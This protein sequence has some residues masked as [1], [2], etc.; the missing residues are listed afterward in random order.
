M[1]DEITFIIYDTIDH[2]IIHKILGKGLAG[3]VILIIAVTTRVI[4]CR[5]PGKSVGKR[6]GIIQLQMILH[7]IIS[8][9]VIVPDIAEL[10][11]IFTGWIISPVGFIDSRIDSV[12]RDA[13]VLV[14]HQPCQSERITLVHPAQ[15]C[16]RRL[17]VGKGIANIT[18]GRIT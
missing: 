3:L 13:G 9:I 5:A 17:N 8:L 14:T 6:T 4:E 12:P 2:R 1:C 10:V 7:I 15:H 16:H 11:I 18:V